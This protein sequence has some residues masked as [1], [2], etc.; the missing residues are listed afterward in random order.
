MTIGFLTFLFIV[1]SSTTLIIC[2][3]CTFVIAIAEVL[4]LPAGNFVRAMFDFKT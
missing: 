1:V 2:I 4:P 3:A